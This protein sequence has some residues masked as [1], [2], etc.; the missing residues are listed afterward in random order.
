MVIKVDAFGLAGVHASAALRAEVGVYVYV[1]HGLPAYSPEGSPYR[2]HCVAV[3][4][5]SA[6]AHGGQERQSGQGYAQP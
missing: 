6:P 1:H 3:P 2:A 5:S 4:P